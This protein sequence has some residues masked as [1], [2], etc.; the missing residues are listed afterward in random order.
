MV[1]NGPQTLGATAAQTVAARGLQT[2]V[3]RNGKR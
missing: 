1:G 3:P 2:S